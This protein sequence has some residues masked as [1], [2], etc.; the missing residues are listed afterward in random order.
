MRINA[1]NF[2]H[3]RIDKISPHFVTTKKRLTDYTEEKLNRWI[4]ENCHGRY[5][6]V[7][8][9][10]YDRDAWRATHVIGFEEP[11]DMTLLALGGALNQDYPP[12]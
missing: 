8:T 4:H 11:S 2:F 7:K 1:R 6:I 3:R 9:V 10:H 12:F 5:C